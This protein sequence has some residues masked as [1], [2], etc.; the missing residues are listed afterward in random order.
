M[1]YL[2][3][4]LTH[5]THLSTS[6]LV[7]STCCHIPLMCLQVECGH[8]IIPGNT[9]DTDTFYTPQH[10]R[11]FVFRCVFRADQHIR[12]RRSY[13]NAFSNAQRRARRV[14][15]R[16]SVAHNLGEGEMYMHTHKTCAAALGIRGA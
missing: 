5:S 13:P 14:C 7:C 1:K 3:T 4:L 2:E 15:T 16:K 6:D 8:Y 12:S 10:I 11:S 9:P